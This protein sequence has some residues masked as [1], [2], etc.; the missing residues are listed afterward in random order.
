VDT[1]T[2]KRRIDA[3]DPSREAAAVRPRPALFAIVALAGLTAVVLSCA[4][5]PPPRAVA[6]EVATGTPEPSATPAPTLVVDVQ[7]AVAHP[8]VYRLA[9]GSRVGD[10]IAAAGGLLPEA[11][12]AGLNRAATLR[13]GARIYAPA[14]GEV[15]PAGS[16][17]SDAERILDLNR[18]TAQELTALPG[19][20]PATADRI[21][22]S[23]E[24]AAFRAVD[25]LQTRGLV[26]ARTLADIRELVSVR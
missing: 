19:V 9:A 3:I 2:A 22:R 13:D 24:K 8:G 10:A 25:E 1:T 26:T 18:A 21:V 20:G 23:R 14:R 15:P 12:P 7:G 6:V 16:L 5:R 4:V 17:G 11:D